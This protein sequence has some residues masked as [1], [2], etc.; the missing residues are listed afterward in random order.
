MITKPTAEW[1]REGE[2]A[3]AAQAAVSGGLKSLASG[4]RAMHGGAMVVQGTIGIGF[5]VL[6]IIAG[7]ASLLGGSVA[8]L[9]GAGL[10]GALAIWLGKRKIAKGKALA[11]AHLPSAEKAPQP[12]VAAGPV[13]AVSPPWQVAGNADTSAFDAD[14]IIARHLA[15]KQ[16]LVASAK[17]EPLPHPGQPMRPAFGRKVA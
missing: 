5:G 15:E 16:R 14:A 6:W 10:M 9:I 4:A 12:A 13:M 2:G 17:V 7:V 11:T 8:T 1:S 3:R